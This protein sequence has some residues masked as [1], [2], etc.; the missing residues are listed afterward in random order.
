M[1]SLHH[2][3]YDEGFIDL[4]S[5]DYEEWLEWVF[6][7][8]HT[9]WPDFCVQDP[10]R[11]VN[12]FIQMCRDF[13]RI[14]KQY[15]HEQIDQAIWFLLSA[16]LEFGRYLLDTSIPLSKRLE[17]L[18]AMYH[19]FADFLSRQGGRYD[20]S[21]FFMWWDLII[22]S[23]FWGPDILSLEDLEQRYGIVW[24]EAVLQSENSR[25]VLKKTL[26]VWEQLYQ[27]TTPDRRALLDETL[28]TLSRILKLEEPCCC[29][30][31][32]HG[33]GHLRHPKG[34]RLVQDFIN[35][36]RAE[37]TDD[38]LRWM[39]NCRDGVVL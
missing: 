3:C 8:D 31:A 26:R 16:Q 14:G 6:T 27:Q 13:A 38:E 36:H 33:L 1:R 2:P 39:R 37:L 32:L 17:C 15:S 9:Q 35:R 29:G 5:M 25:R 28:R 7:T 4:T 21:G 34:W 18:H 23:H 11:L 20:G 22:E 24:K 30:A 10:E 19:P 12:Y